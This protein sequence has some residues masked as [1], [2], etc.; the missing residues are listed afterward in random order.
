MS[1]RQ[2]FRAVSF[3]KGKDKPKP[4]QVGY[5]YKNERGDIVLVIETPP[6]PHLWD[7]RVILNASQGQNTDGGEGRG[8]RASVQSV[9]DDVPF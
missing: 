6:L 4:V 9:D 7:G 1:D 5:G 2:F 8:Q 3:I